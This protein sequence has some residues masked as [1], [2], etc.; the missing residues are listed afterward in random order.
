MTYT[1]QYNMRIVIKRKIKKNSIKIDIN[2]P[3]SID[4]I[5]RDYFDWIKLL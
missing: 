2:L 1:R 4:I 3:L 5:V